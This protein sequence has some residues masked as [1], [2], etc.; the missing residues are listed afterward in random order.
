MVV[1]PSCIQNQLK[2]RDWEK[3]FFHHASLFPSLRKRSYQHQ[4]AGLFDARIVTSLIDLDA[5]PSHRREL[6]PCMFEEGVDGTTRSHKKYARICKNMQ[7]SRKKYMEI[8]K[9]IENPLKYMEL[10][11]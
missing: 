2:Y 10:Y 5:E 6:V 8:R 4:C 7:K 9:Y 1:G 3:P 11:I